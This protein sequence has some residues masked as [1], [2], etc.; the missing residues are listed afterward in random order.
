MTDT[1]RDEGY[2]GDIP[3]GYYADPEPQPLTFDV[4]PDEIFKKAVTARRLSQQTPPQ[5]LQPG[6]EAF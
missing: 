2:H 1:I 3:L 4:D 5:N 6:E